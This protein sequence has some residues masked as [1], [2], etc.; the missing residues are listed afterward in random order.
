MFVGS[1]MGT[2]ENTVHRS[3]ELW[4]AFLVSYTGKH[5]QIHSIPFVLYEQ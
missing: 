5:L 1:Y 2:Q 3:N 4:G